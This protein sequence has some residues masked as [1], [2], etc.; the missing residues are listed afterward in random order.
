MEKKILFVDLDG[1]LL[2]DD[3]EIT[4][5]NLDAIQRAVSL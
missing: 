1:T 4:A 2:T 3:K 5:E